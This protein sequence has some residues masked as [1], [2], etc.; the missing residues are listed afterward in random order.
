VGLWQ[1]LTGRPRV[2]GST[3]GEIERDTGLTADQLGL[4]GTADH[5]ESDHLAEDVGLAPHDLD[6][7]DPPALPA[8]HGD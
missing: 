1:W 4:R 2:D 8:Q 3:L 6:P 7:G 5:E